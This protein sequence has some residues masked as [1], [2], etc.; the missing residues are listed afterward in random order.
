M[1]YIVIIIIIISIILLK[2]GLNI[3]IN[4]MKKIKKIGYD[5]KLNDISNKFPSN[6]EIC[7]EILEKL[8]NKNVNIEE[9][10]DSKTSLYIAITNKIIIAN[11]NDTFTRI[12]TIAHECLH[13]IQNRKILLSNFIFSNISIIAFIIFTILIL[14]NIGNSYIYT[15]IFI[16]IGIIGYVIKAYLENEAMSKAFYLAKEYINEYQEK[17]TDISK[18]D[19]DL[20]IKNFDILNR[21]GIPLTNFYLLIIFLIKVIILC[22]LGIIV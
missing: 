12:Q 14:L 19:I 4:D 2:L 15:Q 13:S 11:I 16:G 21:M 20:L 5:K 10:K 8:N 17:N 7:M 1:E 22:I 9:T 18:D 3:H 6:K